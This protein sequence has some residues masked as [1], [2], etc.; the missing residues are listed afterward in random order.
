MRKLLIVLLVGAPLVVGAGLFSSGVLRVREAA[1]RAHCYG[2]LKGLAVALHTYHDVHKSF[3]P[4][5]IPSE[6]PPERRLGWLVLI[7]P[8][9]GRTG[10]RPQPDPARAWDAAANRPLLNTAIPHFLCPG[11]EGF[12]EAWQ[13]ADHYG[14]NPVPGLTH[15]VGM[16]GVGL[17]AALLPLNDPRAGLFGYDRRVAVE[18]IKDGLGNTLLLLETRREN[19]PWAAGGPATVRGFDPQDT[20]LIGLDRP[21]GNEHRSHFLFWAPSASTNVAFADGSIRTFTPSIDT[22]VFQALATI[23]GEEKGVHFAD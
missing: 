1:N 10:P 12:E 15:Y 16:A 6:L 8:H 22:R 21:F 5:T 9:F 14:A 11:R 23:A 2:H 7:E 18:D 4:G 13:R 17:D 19:G 3:P 20:P